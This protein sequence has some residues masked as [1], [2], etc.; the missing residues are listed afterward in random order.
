M[1]DLAM[2]AI[3]NIKMV[4]AAREEAQRIMAADPDLKQKRF[5]NLKKKFENRTDFH[6]E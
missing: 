5:T 2:E 1:S 4:E 6:F 3:Q